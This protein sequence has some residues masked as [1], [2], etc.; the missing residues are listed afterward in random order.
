MSPEDLLTEAVTAHEDGPSALV[1]GGRMRAVLIRVALESGLD[2]YWQRHDPTVAKGSMRSQLLVLGAC[3]PEIADEVAEAWHSLCRMAHHH[4]Y[5]LPP[6]SLE[7]AGWGDRVSA[8]LA[9]LAAGRP[10][11][12]CRPECM[13][14]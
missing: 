14:G 13:A 10:H 3:W 5:E 7:L 4:L 11:A 1:Y 9:K 12:V 6:A 2:L 8:L